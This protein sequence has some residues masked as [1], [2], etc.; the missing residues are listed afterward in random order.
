MDNELDNHYK[1]AHD[2]S[3]V[4]ARIM[5]NKLEKKAEAID[6]IGRHLQDEQ[7]L[8]LKKYLHQLD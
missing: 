6:G 7:H 8:W 4:W 3:T 2:V 5:K 1:D